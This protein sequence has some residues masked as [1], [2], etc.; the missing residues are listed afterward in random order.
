MCPT[1]TLSGATAQMLA[2]PTSKWGRDREERVALLRMRT[3]PE[4]P[5]DNLRELA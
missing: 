3:R 4:C 1:A 2:S 5:E